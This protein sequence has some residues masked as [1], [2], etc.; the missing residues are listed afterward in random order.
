VAVTVVGLGLV[1]GGAWLLVGGGVRVLTLAGLSAGFVGAGILGALTSLDEVLLE[2]LP[3]RRGVP[4]LATGN[5]FGTLAAFTTGVL[6][7]AAVV[8]PLALD[9]GANLA[10][11]AAAAL[12][13]L[14]GT[15]FFIRGRAG[16]VLGFVVLATYLAWLV[17][18]AAA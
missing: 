13:A 16:R 8:R 10:F 1:S 7:L 3:V 6:G 14:V 15:V 11:L 12:Y 18:A 2:V 9:A 4:E 17:A 5:L